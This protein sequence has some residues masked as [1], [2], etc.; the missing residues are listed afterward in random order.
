MIQLDWVPCASDLAVF[1]TAPA[2][3]VAPEGTTSWTIDV[4]NEGPHAAQAAR[5]V[6]VVP[7]EVDDVTWTCAAVDGASCGASNGSGNRIDELLQIPVGGT[8]TLVVTGKIGD[9]EG[10][11]VL[12]NT[13]RVTVADTDPDPTNNESTATV[14]VESWPALKLVKTANVTDISGADDQIRYSFTVTNTGNTNLDQLQINETTFTGS[15]T[16]SDITCPV[17]DLAPATTTT[18]TA[19]YT[20]TQTDI[21]SG[22]ITNTAT[23]TAQSPTGD[24]VTSSESSVRVAALDAPPA[25]ATTGADTDLPVAVATL[26]LL[27]GAWMVANRRKKRAHQ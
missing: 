17:A 15:G 19:T 23:A 16:L 11:T 18:C 7:S 5:L 9:L 6:D 1:K 14:E 4:T 10:G 8:A 27:A 12:T 24:T 3:T 21:D 13:A 22:A 20:A 2:P 25:L 26:L